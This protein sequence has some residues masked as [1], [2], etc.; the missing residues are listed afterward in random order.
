MSITLLYWIPWPGWASEVPGRYMG[1]V[2]PAG[3]LGSDYV[4]PIADEFGD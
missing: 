2:P 4:A 3:G 1:S